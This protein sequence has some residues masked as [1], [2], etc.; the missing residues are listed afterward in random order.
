MSENVFLPW[1]SS[2]GWAY[3]GILLTDT[4]APVLNVCFLLVALHQQHQKLHQRPQLQATSIKPTSS[5]STPITTPSFS[6]YASI[7]GGFPR[8][9]DLNSVDFLRNSFFFFFK[10]KLRRVFTPLTR[11]P[12]NSRYLSNGHILTILYRK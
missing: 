6:Y 5:S 8:L 12:L 7:A 4:R 11:N 2:G 10:Q 1:N 3:S 9:S